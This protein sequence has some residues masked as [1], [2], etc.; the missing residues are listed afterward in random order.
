MLTR[1]RTWHRPLVLFTVLMGALTVVS[2]VGMVVDDRQ[3]EG[4]SVWLKPLKFDLSFI[5]FALTWAWLLSLPEHTTRFLNRTA[6]VLVGGGLVEMVIIT[7]QAARGRMSHFNNTTTLD[8]T[9]FQIMGATVV[10]IWVATLLLTIKLAAQRLA[11]RPELL[12]IRLGM[13]IS[14]VGMLIGFLMTINTSS[15]VEGIVG[16]HA[17]GVPDGG[18]GMPLTNWSTTGGDLRIPHFLG[19]H[20]VQLLPIVGLLLRR[21]TD[22]RSAVRLVW[23]LGLGYAGLFALLTWQAIRG[24]SL[25]HPDWATGTAFGVLVVGVALGALSSR[26]G[27]EVAVA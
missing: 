17:V 10:V 26:R 8:G 24:Q 21:R 11:P 7:V 12:A 22:E 23:T 4:V 15:G 3:L 20:A 5:L 1:V 13:V 2:L 14:L 9:L 16:A 19:L 25:I 27:S 6:T 18:P